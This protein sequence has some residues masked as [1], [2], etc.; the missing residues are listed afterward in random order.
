MQLHAEPEHCVMPKVLGLFVTAVFILGQ[1]WSIECFTYHSTE[2]LTR[3]WPYCCLCSC[4]MVLPEFY[5]DVFILALKVNRLWT[6][7]NFPIESTGAKICMLF[8]NVQTLSQCRLEMSL[9]ALGLA[10]RLH[11]K[12]PSA[13]ET[14]YPVCTEEQW[15]LR[16]K[17]NVRPRKRQDTFCCPLV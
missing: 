5:E 9:Y 11:P 4:R 14:A 16:C 6:L 15:Q 8:P 1:H 17:L 7:P 13:E 2:T 3:N 12:W 10:L